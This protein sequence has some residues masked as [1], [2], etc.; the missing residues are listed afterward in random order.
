MAELENVAEVIKKK[1]RKKRRRFSY[2]NLYSFTYTAKHTNRL[3]EYDRNPLIIPLY[4][5]PKS[6]LGLNLHWVNPLFRFQ[7]VQYIMGVS[8]QM[9]NKR[10]VVRITYGMLKKDAFLNSGLKGVRRYL[11]THMKNSVAIPKDEIT[12]KILRN[13]KYKANVVDGDKQPV[14]MAQR[15]KRTAKKARRKIIRW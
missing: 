3:E 11:H 13:S 15:F 4:I 7:V 8:G 9:T 2:D 5:G 1:R 6:T 10:K 12:T 14:G